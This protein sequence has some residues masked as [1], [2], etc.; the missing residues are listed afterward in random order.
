MKKIFVSGCYD[1]VHAGHIQFFIEA[2]AL[3]EHLTVCIASDKVLML[4]KKRKPSLPM[5]HKK[6]LI[7]ALEMVD[8]VVIGENLEKGLDFKKHFLHIKPNILAV[9]EDDKYN[10]LKRDLCALIGAEY[11]VLPKTPPKIDQTNT[12]TILAKIQAPQEVPLRVDFAGG[13]LDVPRFSKKGGFIVNCA[14]TPLVSLNKWEYEKKSGLGGSAAWAILNGKDGIKSE[15]NLGVGWQDPAI[16]YE[17]GLCVW[18]SGVKPELYLKRN[19][20]MLKGLMAIYFTNDDHDTPLIVDIKRNYSL[21]YKAGQIA[22]EAIINEDLTQLANAVRVSY[23]VQL[24][25]GM[26]HL[27]EVDN[28]IAQK[29]CGGGWGGYALYLFSSKLDR[30]N[31]VNDNPQAKSIEPFMN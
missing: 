21:I 7:H 19:C 5:D 27:L 4:E 24:N 30:E 28:C 16:I 8:D 10:E 22:C 23:K 17:T 6:S 11:F 13:W 25:E 26:N 18:N 29:Y 14:I 2:K 15:L 12:S 9:T 3:G 1:I 31:F 20:N